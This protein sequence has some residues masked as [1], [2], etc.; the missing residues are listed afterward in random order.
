MNC[1]NCGNG[2][3]MIATGRF[4]REALPEEVKNVY[5]YPVGKIISTELK[6]RDCGH[7]ENNKEI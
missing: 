1:P 2:N 3:A 5:P 7:I 4:T 6:C